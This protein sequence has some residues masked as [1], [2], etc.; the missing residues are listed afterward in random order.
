MAASKGTIVLAT[1][2]SEVRAAKAVGSLWLERFGVSALVVMSV[3]LSAACIDGGGLCSE[4]LLRR[5]LP[6][7]LTHTASLA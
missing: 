4:T 7:Y 3:L 2:N 1:D 5:Y 6:I